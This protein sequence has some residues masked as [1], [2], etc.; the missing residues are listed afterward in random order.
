MDSFDYGFALTVGL[1]G[2]IAIGIVQAS[3]GNEAA[4]NLAYLYLGTLFGYA[5]HKFCG[6]DRHG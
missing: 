3:A 1:L 2:L 5:L 6:S 4:L